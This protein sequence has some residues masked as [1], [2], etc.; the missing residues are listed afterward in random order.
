MVSTR[1]ERFDGVTLVDLFTDGNKRGTITAKSLAK[2]IASK[3]N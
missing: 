1:C 2:H 3:L